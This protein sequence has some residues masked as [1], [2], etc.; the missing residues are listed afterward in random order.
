MAWVSVALVPVLVGGNREDL[1]LS[2]GTYWKCVCGCV[3][4]CATATRWLRPPEKLAALSGGG[5]SSFT[6]GLIICAITG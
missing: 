4:E 1:T 6:P 2:A 5:R 3:G